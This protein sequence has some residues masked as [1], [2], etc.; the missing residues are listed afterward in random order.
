GGWELLEDRLGVFV[1]VE[2]PDAW[3]IGDY[4]GASPQEPSR[5]LRGVT[6]QANPSAPNTRFFLRLTTVVDDDLMLP[7]AV[8]ARVASPTKFTRRRRV[9]ARDYFGMETVAAHSAFN[10][11]A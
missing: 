4:T 3:P 6:S 1:V 7:A 11:A 2:D 8:D 10:T 9:D 5:T